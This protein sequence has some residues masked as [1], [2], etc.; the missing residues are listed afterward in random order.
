MK[1]LFSILLLLIAFAFS[2]DVKPLYF[3]NVSNDS[4]EQ[5]AEWDYL[6][7]YKM[8]GAHGIEFAGQNINVPDKSGWFGT[9]DGDWTLANTDHKVGGPI[10]IGG[11]ISFDNGND[12]LTTGP[13]N[14]GGNIIIKQEGFKDRTNAFLSYQ[15]V[16]GTVD[17]KYYKYGHVEDEYQF[18]GDNYSN[19]PADVPQ[20]KTTL[21]I[22]ELKKDTTYSA[23]LSAAGNNLIYIDVPPDTTMYDLYI[24]KISLYADAKLVVRMPFGGRLTRIF[25]KDGFF[26]ENHG[27]V[28]VMYMSEDAKFEDGKWTGDGIALDNRDYSGNLLFYTGDVGFSWAARTQTDS[29]Q[30]TYITTGKISIQQQMTLAGQLLANEL[31]INANFDGSGFLYVPFD[32]PELNI[33]PTAL[34]SGKFI[35]NNIDTKI[36]IQLDTL[37]K[38][39]VYFKYC[40]IVKDS[41]GNASIDDFNK[42]IP[43]CGESEKTVTILEGTKYPTED[44]YLNVKADGIKE[45]EEVLKM[46]I[47]DLQGA[48]MPGNLHQGYFSLYL[49][50]G[51]IYEINTDGLAK[52]IPENKKD[53]IIGKVTID[54]GDTTTRFS[55]TNPKYVIDSITGVITLKEEYDYEVK[56]KDTIRIIAHDSTKADT[57]DYVINILDVNENPII[58]DQTFSIPENYG[59]KDSVGIVIVSDIDNTKEFT[60]NKIVLADTT[61]F[62]VKDNKI[63]P[64]KSFDYESKD[65]VQTIKIY[66]IDVNDNKLKDSATVT[67]KI[68]NQNEGI[69]VSGKIEN[70]KENVDIG[71]IVGVITAKDSDNVDVSYEINKPYF[72]IDPVTGVIT[73]NTIMN[74]EVQNEYPVTV[75]IKSKDDSKKDTTITIKLVDVNEAPELKD[76]EL[77]IDE[78]KTGEA[79]TINVY[80]DDKNPNFLKNELSIIEGDTSKFKIE[81]NKVIVK[82][83]LDYEQDSIYTIKVKVQDKTDPTLVDTMTYV[84]KVN[85]VPE[86][87]EVKDIATNVDENKT[88]ILDTLKASDPDGD[89]LKYEVVD[90][91]N[92]KVD[93]NGVISIIKPFDYETDSTIIAHI[94]VT[95]PTGLK[96]TATISLKVNDVN[97]PHKVSDETITIPEDTTKTFKSYPIDTVKVTDPDLNP[98][99]KFEL[100]DTTN[101]FKID[102][103]GVITVI[104]P[105]D[106]ETVKE[107]NVKVIVSD[108]LYTDIATIKIKVN[109]IDEK[110]NVQIVHVDTQD[111]VYTET[112]KPIYTNDKDIEIT[113]KSDDKHKDTTITGLKEGE[114]K[115]EICDIGVG[116]DTKACD[117]VTVWYS[118]KTP[119]ITVATIDKNKTN[120]NNITIIDEPDGNQ[121]VNN[122]NPEIKV[123]VK[124]P[125]NAKKDTTFNINVDLKTVDVP[126][127]SLIN[128]TIEPIDIALTPDAKHEVIGKDSVK[129]TYYDPIAKAT[130]SYVT[131]SEG[132]RINDEF[133]VSWVEKVNGQDVTISY[134]TDSYVEVKSNYSISYSVPQGKDTITVSYQVD[135]DGKIQKTNGNVG[136][137]ISYSYTNA[138]GNTGTSEIQVVL[139]DVPPKVEIY[140]LIAGKDTIYPGEGKNWTEYVASS[141]IIVF[142]TVDGKDQDTLTLQGLKAE[143]I[144]PIVR[145]YQDKANNQT[146]DTVMVYAKGAKEIEIKIAHPV[147]EIDK[148]RVDSFYNEGGKYNP[149]KPIQ[150]IAQDASE[151]K[152]PEPVGVGIKIGLALPILNQ[153][154]GMPTADDIV[155]TID[156]V[157][158]IVID[159]N[160]NVVT[161]AIAEIRDNSTKIISVDNYIENYCTDQYKEE[162]RKNG[163]EKVP[164]YDMKYSMHVWIFNNNANYVN[165]F[166][167]EYTIDE[168]QKVD[169]SGMLNLMVDWLA[170]KDGYVKAKN[171]KAIGTGAYI[172]KISAVSVA[173]A[174][175]TL[176]SDTQKGTKIKKDETEMFT[177]GYKRP[178]SK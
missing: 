96:D 49:I 23:A 82:K 135:S 106:Y 20:I 53:T 30:G 41:I 121:Y 42:E 167:F 134:T 105:L 149:K 11:N 71:T 29:L 77:K 99:H 73:T 178:I 60:N 84:V 119:I 165:D 69:N 57:V 9:A 140:K 150:I 85:N 109:N 147:T 160:G 74:Y 157:T 58:K 108:N 81:D 127:K 148:D 156:G 39:N 128:K 54:G 12:S 55:I 37:A 104:K 117:T 142:W 171:G 21:E 22:P 139:D 107:Y 14:V 146:C 16:K 40:F 31:Y 45:G 15:C 98:N 166:N 83:A 172:G 72:K 162:V 26:F 17:Q 112:D 152:L 80:D 94:V 115:I 19:C 120:V 145:C 114:N 76:S 155:Q 168:N 75:T 38:T 44:L 65:T 174:K 1:K 6:M 132:K 24:E 59:T 111:S 4:I 130:V 91:T 61:N 36:P 50:D 170:A 138:Y 125:T 64:K 46:K 78:N 118:N 93:S 90:N 52:D 43:I 88:G 102:S 153:N 123:T 32:P 144:N 47:Y 133:T 18:F 35:E 131:N 92:I 95:D 126:V 158:G 129:V 141:S 122:K 66:A 33:D 13:V 154:G 3:N 159:G 8:F 100:I 124:D 62:R 161:D 137:T 10:I 56:Q 175:C 86:K 110:S 173:K 143:K 67:I 5:Q 51:D 151:D 164:F 97:E 176:N 116:K 25:L 163:I 27:R 169:A 34:A 177:F 79:G 68:T 63:Y 70:V 103:N 48:V 2:A 7:K 89:K 87:P 101:T 136:Y 28:Q 113:Y